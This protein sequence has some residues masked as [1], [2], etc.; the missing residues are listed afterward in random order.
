MVTLSVIR[1]RD[2]SAGAR[3]VYAELALRSFME[4]FGADD[5]DVS[6]GEIA[7]ALGISTRSVQT[8]VGELVKA[9]LVEKR[10]RGRGF[11]NAFV[12]KAIEVGNLR[13]TS[14]KSA[15]E[16]GKIDRSHSLSKKREDSARKP[17]EADPVFDALSELF[18]PPPRA[19]L[20]GKR[21]REIRDVV[22]AL[23]S[24]AD[25]R[26]PG[27]VFGDAGM[28]VADD[29]KAIVLAA[30]AALRREWGI[31]R[32]TVNS[33]VEN[34]GLALQ[35]AGVSKVAS[36]KTTTKLDASDSEYGAV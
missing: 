26:R 18:G 12:L 21:G 5:V 30:G 20:Y 31:P 35:L 11:A 17:R 9:G 24:I 4:A 2:L 7:D 28:L 27:T 14:A 16:V 1:N 15:D 13:R 6:H 25:P 19:S 3:V 33:L 34:F 29:W 36:A 23:G 32:V 8:Y 22:N 10:S